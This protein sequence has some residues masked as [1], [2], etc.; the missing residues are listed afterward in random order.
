MTFCELIG[1][2]RQEFGLKAAVPVVKQDDRSF[3]LRHT[4]MR[5]CRSDL[6]GGFFESVSNWTA[7]RLDEKSLI[8]R[9]ECVVINLHVIVT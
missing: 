1:Y 8:F 3:C 5:L 2:F 7:S 6:F 4:Q 9:A